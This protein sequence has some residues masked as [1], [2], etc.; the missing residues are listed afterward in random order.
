MAL[1]WLTRLQETSLPIGAL[2][3]FSNCF[4]GVEVSINASN[5][6]L[7]APACKMLFS[8]SSSFFS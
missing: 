5:T 1:N 8:L 2:A 3:A 4:I 6:F 7:V